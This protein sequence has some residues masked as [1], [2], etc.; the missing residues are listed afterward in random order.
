MFYFRISPGKLL[1]AATLFIACFFACTKD[2]IQ[3]FP[4]QFEN[5]AK[6]PISLFEAK[7]FFSTFRTSNPN[8]LTDNEFIE[9]DPLW[10]QATLSHSPSGKEIIVVPLPDSTL[11]AM[12]DD[13]VGAK[14]LFSKN[15][16]DSIVAEI[17]VHVVDSA[18]FEAKNHQPV[19]ADFSGLFIFYD[20]TQTFKV[21]LMM[22]NGV[23]VRKLKSAQRSTSTGSTVVP[24]NDNETTEDCIDH[25]YSQLVQY[26]CPHVDI[27]LTDCYRFEVIITTVCNSTDG[28]GGGG[29]GGTNGDTGGSSVGG[30]TTGGSN[31]ANEFQTVLWLVYNGHLPIS[32]LNSFGTPGI[33]LPDSLR[34]HHIPMLVEIQR[35]CKFK[36]ASTSTG[37]PTIS[38][39][40][41]SFEF[42]MR[43]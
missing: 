40:K 11:R 2:K 35:F 14:L 20:L 9:L 32:A 8:G 7:D 41:G 18:Y 26:P 15:G 17:L 38:F 4:D 24:R 25:I 31:N 3:P 36:P 13:K 43:F 22:A 39:K 10:H 23:P 5:S 33:F 16:P 29:N 27:P 34:L 37:G 12:N 28:G 1:L 30:G 19:L 21:G 42:K 6:Y